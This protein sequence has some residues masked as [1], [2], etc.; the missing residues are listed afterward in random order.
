MAILL[1]IIFCALAHTNVI[2]SVYLLYLYFLWLDCG[3]QDENGIQKNFFPNLLTVSDTI[4]LYTCI[5]YRC[6][7]SRYFY[8]F[9][10]FQFQTLTRCTSPRPP[11]LCSFQLD[12]HSALLTSNRDETPD[13]LLRLLIF[14]I[15]CIKAR[16]FCIVVSINTNL[17]II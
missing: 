2:Q 6:E 13:S 9:E 11:E 16:R 17:R 14:T 3:H 10:A 12:V 15:L 4:F 8:H 7:T 5:K 1:R